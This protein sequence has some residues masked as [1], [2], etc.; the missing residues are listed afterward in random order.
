MIAYPKLLCLTC[1]ALPWA[2]AQTSGDAADHWPKELDGNGIHFLLYQ[3]QVDSWKKNHLEARSAVTVTRAGSSTPIY[4]IVSISARTDSDKDTRMVTLEDLKVTSASFPADASQQSELLDLLRQSLPAWPRTISL[5]RLLADLALTDA[6]ADTESVPVNNTPPK[7]VFSTTPSVLILIDGEPIYRSLPGFPYSHVINTPALMLFNSA[8]GRFYLDGGNLWMTA[9][10]LNGPWSRATNP[11]SDLERAKTQL[12]ATEEKDPH[13]HS[14]DVTAAQPANGAPPTVYVSTVPAELLQTK[15]K[16]RFSPIKK[17]KL[18]Y[19]TNTQN[20]IF[21]D[22]KTQDYYTLLAGRWFKAKSLNGPWSFVPGDQL[23]RD[24]LRIPPDSPKG[25]VLASIPGTEQAKEAMIANQIP[26]TASVKRSAAKLDVHYDGKPRFKPIQGTSMEYAVNTPDDVILAEGRYYACH[27]A[28]WFVA[29]SPTGP[30][31]VADSVPPEIYTIPPSNPLFHDRYVYAYDSTPDFVD[32]GYT[33]GYMGAF[34]SNGVVVFGTGW[35]YPGWYGD[36]YY[37]WPWTWGLGY[38]YGYWGGGVF[39]PPYGNPWYHGMPYMNRIYGNQWNPQWNP[40]DRQVFQNNANV[41][42]RWQR[43]AVIPRATFQRQAAAIG[44]GG[45]QFGNG[46]DLYAGRDGNV[47]ERRQ[48]GW[49]QNNNSGNW[50]RVS[51]NPG[52]GLERQQMSR[53]FGESRFNE[54]RGFGGGSP[55]FSRMPQTFAPSFGG[56]GGGRVGG[57]PVGGFRR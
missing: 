13:D 47:Y 36:S 31:A 25:P 46:R 54:F 14:K 12:T 20:D 21:M 26:Q 45:S 5:D 50:N 52:L 9:T 33:P 6:L 30:W 38:N 27:N 4:G 39:M 41:Y 8:A 57:G 49:F 51:P 19:V 43:N 55:G 32:F 53:S 22:V 40:G 17:T 37:G 42:N 34:G 44:A 3:P 29:D 7:I 48:N 35:D 11:P 56:F 10:N 23:P 24:F 18:S 16:P 2:V 15:G 28:V 1:I